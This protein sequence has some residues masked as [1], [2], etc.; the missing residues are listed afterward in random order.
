ME[1]F[2]IEEAIDQVREGTFNDDGVL[3]Y[4]LFL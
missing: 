1:E 3:L 2:E 4:L